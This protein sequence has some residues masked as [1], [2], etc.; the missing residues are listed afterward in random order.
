MPFLDYLHSPPMKP[1]VLPKTKMI[2]DDANEDSIVGNQDISS[3][4]LT[5]TSNKLFHFTVQ[6]SSKVMFARI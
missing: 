3:F 6:L 1:Q 4:S 2:C 5:I